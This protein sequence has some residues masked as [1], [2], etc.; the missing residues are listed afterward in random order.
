METG[1]TI[2]YILGMPAMRFFAFKKSMHDYMAKR[3]AKF[4]AEIIPAIRTASADKEY[5][6]AVQNY[7]K[8][9]YLPDTEKRRMTQGKVFDLTNNEDQQ[10]LVDYFSSVSKYMRPG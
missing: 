3:A 10:Y 4:M 7:Y 8:S 2:E 5:V 9:Y 1:W 6:E